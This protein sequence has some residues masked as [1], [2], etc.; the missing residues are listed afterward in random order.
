MSI[1]IGHNVRSQF[2]FIQADL[3]ANAS[4]ELVAP[5][6]GFIVELNG[7][8]QT[9]VTTGGTIKVAINGVDVAGLTFTVPNA[10]T[11]GTRYSATATKGSATRAV[12]KGDRIQIIP[13]SFATAG[14]AS[15]FIAIA[16]QVVG[17]EN[18]V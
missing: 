11:K 13:T 4:Q 5:A 8:I 18:P 15:G 3:V 14:A 7:I 1:S 12:K 9:N 6:D 16:S 10:A 2:T 17:E